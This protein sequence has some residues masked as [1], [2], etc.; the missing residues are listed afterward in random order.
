[1]WQRKTTGIVALALGVVLIIAAIID[2]AFAAPKAALC[3]SDIGQIGQ[4]IDNTVAH[5]CG[6]V[7]GLE[8]A[9]GWLIAFG[10]LAIVLGAT[11]LYRSRTAPRPLRQPPASP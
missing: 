5:D 8:S 6:L 10:I 4:A 7:T 1:M 3:G 2:H 11:V 9:V